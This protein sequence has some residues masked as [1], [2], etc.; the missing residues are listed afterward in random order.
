MVASPLGI[1]LFAYL[2]FILFPVLCLE[3]YLFNLSHLFSV[4]V[5]PVYGE[6]LALPPGHFSALA[7]G[8]RLH[9]WKLH[10]PASFALRHVVT[11]SMSVEVSRNTCHFYI[12]AIKAW[13]CTP[14]FFLPFLTNQN[15]AM[16]VTQLPP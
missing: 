9:N 12:L 13:S 15:R 11:K 14:S 4:L 8:T 3:T 7:L 16:P 2:T 6:L 10:F 1:S 5:L